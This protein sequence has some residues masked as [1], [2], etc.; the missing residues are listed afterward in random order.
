MA[1]LVSALV[2]L[3]KPYR[4][5]NRISRWLRGIV[6]ARPQY[7][8]IGIP[9]AV[10]MFTGAVVVPN[11][12]ATADSA[13]VA[14]ETAHTAIQATVTDTNFRWPFVYFGISQYFTGYHQ[15]MDL[16]NPAGTPVYP[17]ANGTV[18]E[19][20]FFYTGYGKH[21]IVSHDSGVTSLYAHLS[22]I[23]VKAGQAV[24]KDTKLG[25][26]GATGWA[27]GNHLHLEIRQNGV[28]ANPLEILPQFQ[29]NVPKGSLTQAIAAPPIPAL[30]L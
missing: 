23:D 9:L 2:W 30:S 27:T 8:L 1:G 19:V 11:V 25:S 7:Q 16:T 24:T 15:A 29:K 28:A 6:E 12:K 17:V 14:R 4:G 18:S 26:V 13:T 20:N 21:V 10:V 5:S 22:G 3:T